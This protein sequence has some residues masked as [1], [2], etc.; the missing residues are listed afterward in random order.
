MLAFEN[1]DRVGGELQALAQLLYLVLHVAH[2]HLRALASYAG[3]DEEQRVLPDDER[4]PRCHIPQR[5]YPMAH[6][7]LR[8]R[9]G[10]LRLSAL[11]QR[12]L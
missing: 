9:V 2:A 1:E 3:M 10:T 4:H 7:S 6:V 5:V 12:M 11:V 8:Y